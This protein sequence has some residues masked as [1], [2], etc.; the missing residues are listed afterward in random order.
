MMAKQRQTPVKKL[1][2]QAVSGTEKLEDSRNS[3]ESFRGIET[4]NAEKARGTT[5]GEGHQTWVKA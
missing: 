2:E 5:G 4:I 3:G 1:M